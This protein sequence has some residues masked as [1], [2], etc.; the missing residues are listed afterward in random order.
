MTSVHTE[1]RSPPGLRHPSSHLQHQHHHFIHQSLSSTTTTTTSLASSSTSSSGHA[2]SVLQR[3]STFEGNKDVM[4][5]QPN[6]S[7]HSLAES[8]PLIAKPVKEGHVSLIASRFQQKSSVDNSSTITTAPSVPT[9]THSTSSVRPSSS[10]SDPAKKAE[11][12]SSISLNN[13][14]K[15]SEIIVK[16]PSRA[17]SEVSEDRSSSERISPL[18]S[19]PKKP[20][21]R[22]ES[23][24]AR[25][26]TARAMFEKMGSAEELDN[27]TLPP[28]KGSSSP[29]SRSSSVG[30]S[31]VMGGGGVVD[32]GFKQSSAYFRSRS[33]SPLSASTMSNNDRSPSRAKST[34][35]P[36]TEGV[37]SHMNGNLNSSLP[38]S[39]SYQNGLAETVGLVKSRRLSFQQK[40]NELGQTKTEQPDHHPVKRV[41]RPWMNTNQNQI[42]CSN[43]SNGDVSLNV[44][45]PS[46]NNSNNDSTDTA[47]ESVDSSRRISVKSGNAP[48]L[49]SSNVKEVPAKSA[50]PTLTTPV[51]EE[52]SPSANLDLPGD[53]R[54]LSATASNA[55]DSIED[56][57]RNWKKSPT[58]SPDDN[59]SMSDDKIE[60]DSKE[61][62]LSPVHSPK[63]KDSPSPLGSGSSNTH[64]STSGMSAK[65]ATPNTT[66]K[67]SSFRSKFEEI[68][69][70]TAARPPPVSPK[71]TPD[72]VK[73]FSFSKGADHHQGQN[74]PV[75][76]Q[77]YT[78]T[79][80]ITTTTRIAAVSTSSATMTNNSASN[81]NNHHPYS[82][83]FEFKSLD[84]LRSN[85]LMGD[86]SELSSL[87]SSDSSSS[88][89]QTRIYEVSANVIDEKEI[90]ELLEGPKRRTSDAS[91]TSNSSKSSSSSSSRSNG[92]RIEGSIPFVD[93]DLSEAL[94]KEEDELTLSGSQ[95]NPDTPAFKVNMAEAVNRIVVEKPTRLNLSSRYRPPA[96]L[97]ASENFSPDD[98]SDK[99]SSKAS[100]TVIRLNHDESRERID[101]GSSESDDFQDEI[102]FD[103]TI[104]SGQIGYNE[105]GFRNTPITM[106]GPNDRNSTA[107]PPDASI[108]GSVD[109]MTPTEAEKLL[110]TELSEKRLSDEQA[111]EVVALL[112]PPDKE[113]PPLPFESKEE[114]HGISSD[115]GS[116]IESYTLTASTKHEVDTHLPETGS[117]L[118]KLDSLV[119]RSKSQEPASSDYVSDESSVQQP[120]TKT[121]SNASGIATG[122][123]PEK[124]HEVHH[125]QKSGVHYFSDGH[126]WFEIAAIDESS[127]R[128]RL[129]DNF[130]KAPGKLRFSTEGIRQFSTFGVDEYDRRNED[131]DPVAASA[132]YELE[133]R[134]EKMDTF[135]VNLNKGKDGLGLSII[136]MGV[137]A[138]AGLEKLGIFIKTITPNGLAHR[139]GRI[140]VNDQIIEVDD[141]IDE[142]EIEELLEGPKRRTSDASSTSNSSKSSSSSSSRSNGTRIE[143]SIPFVDEDL[144]EALVK[145]EDELTLSGSQKNPDTP[146][147][148]VNMAEAVNRIVVEKPTRLNLSS[149]Y[150]PPASL[151]ASENFSPDDNSDKSS[152]KAST[153]VIRLNHD[154]SRERID[155]G[156]SESDDFQDE[157]QFDPT[158]SS[159]ASIDGSVDN[160]TPTEAEKLLSTELSEKRLSDEQA[161]EVVALLSLR[162]KSYHPFPSTKHEVDTHL[163]ETGSALDKLDSLVYRSKSQEPAS[164]DYVSDESSVQQPKTKTKS[165]ASGIA[166]GFVPEKIHEV[167]HDQKSPGKLRFSTEGIRQ[168]STFGVDEYDRRNEDVDP[169]AASAEYELEKRVEKM[170]T[171]PVNLNKGKD[172]LGLSIIGMGVGADA[173]LE[174]L[175]I[176]IKTITPNGLAHRDGR[177]Q[178]N[179]QIIEVD[180][181]ERADCQRELMAQ[182][183]REASLDSSEDQ[184][185]ITNSSTVEGEHTIQ[186]QEGQNDFL[187]DFDEAEERDEDDEEEEDDKT[188]ATTPDVESSN[189]VFGKESLNDAQ[190]LPNFSPED[191][192]LLKIKLEE[193]QT[194]NTEIEEEMDHIK[195]K[196]TDISKEEEELSSNQES[197]TSEKSDRTAK[198]ALER[199]FEELRRKYIQAKKVIAGL[200][201]HECFR[202]LQL[203]EQNRLL[204]DRVIQ[205]EQELV[206]TQKNAGMP[207]RLPYEDSL[208]TK[209]N[210][211]DFSSQSQSMSMGLH[212][213]EDISETELEDIS[214]S[215]SGPIK[216]E[217]DK[218]FPSHDLLDISASKSKAELV[219]K[220]ALSNRSKPSMDALRTSILRRSLSASSTIE[221]VTEMNH[222]SD[223]FHEGL[224]TSDSGYHATVTQVTAVRQHFGKAPMP[225]PSHPPEFMRPDYLGEFQNGQNQST[226]E[227]LP[228]SS[229]LQEKAPIASSTPTTAS[230]TWSKPRGAVALPGFGT[231]PGASGGVTMADQLKSRLEE[232]R[233]SGHSKDSPSAAVHGDSNAFVPESIITSMEH[234]VKVANDNVRKISPPISTN[235]SSSSSSSLGS[236][237]ATPPHIHAMNPHH[238][239]V[240]AQKH[241]PNSAYNE[242]GLPPSNPHLHQHISSQHQISHPI[243]IRFP[244][245]SQAQQQPQQTQQSLHQMRAPP[246]YPNYPHPG[247]GATVSSTS[248]SSSN[249]VQ[250]VYVSNSPQVV[251]HPASIEPSDAGVIPPEYRTSFHSSTGHGGIPV[252]V[253]VP[254]PHVPMLSGPPAPQSNSPRGSGTGSSNNSLRSNAA[255][256]D[257]NSH[258]R[259]DRPLNSQSSVMVQMVKEQLCQWLLAMEMR[260]YLTYFMDSEL[261]DEDILCLDNNGL[262]DLGVTNKSEREK[263]RKKIKELK[264]LYD[265]DKKEMEKER[266]RKDSLLKKAEKANR[267][268]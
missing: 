69:S 160:M 92:T 233:R 236:N 198:E 73:K 81:S 231:S 113:L 79:A 203:Q 66:G 20:V 25:F 26:N 140:Q 103:P 97:A 86:E 1:V 165:N 132:E 16:N 145:E 142:K 74:E 94:V 185:S 186:P 109:N 242:I 149:R 50:N 157:I 143:G 253:P 197:P 80:S 138:D 214:I 77:H 37:G 141:V 181:K 193:A 98:N 106:G 262:R 175:G 42:K 108:D 266:K 56:Y 78:A 267:K 222:G 220:S 125:D 182:L 122:F 152:S 10:S 227:N 196:L 115:I 201:R 161:K 7:S 18:R 254:P 224:P 27:S 30:R 45:T 96:S 40:Q 84:D 234:A 24:H 213:D 190:N 111:K 153:T 241:S 91:S 83:E 268:K 117:A 135:P 61:P 226:Y 229:P 71:P 49:L 5:P 174:K 52:P 22:T 38:S 53:R 167:H 93:E 129:P 95:K 191:I 100:T 184:T 13:S 17:P 139:D 134:V 29:T 151:A 130:Y 11:A 67:V 238:S 36:T 123:V 163:P 58:R 162:I 150:G 72:I 168:F 19:S 235:M 9:V 232:R 156:S 60:G 31:D 207:V 244:S 126:Y 76:D 133:K 228:I 261:S 251:P 46:N 255:G 264:A 199:E 166:T 170:D 218:L 70:T 239:V 158:I 204:T 209:A 210:N 114:E 116:S 189:M 248:S 205:L 195:S 159:D 90:E 68:Q 176:F 110:S 219:Q 131:V 15:T 75:Q 240:I 57:I 127:A 147:F 41:Q 237:Q 137:G 82:S 183:E 4:K 187:N 59:L 154:E 225:L 55:S 155:S 256:S 180:D 194:R 252:S 173:G 206:N 211:P 202:S 33:S 177:I 65:T 247:F 265:K 171:F 178:V 101:S 216:E 124:I 118:D 260:H 34:P 146:A 35:S 258:G 14:R 128:E 230:P 32:M 215:S 188:L 200:K 64:S 8:S 192:N 28:K 179:D 164:S 102:Q 105:G 259:N 107:F 172:G 246:P 23:H 243:P 63:S 121:K 250:T 51:I 99:S 120:K 223:D 144:S 43:S 47:S 6:R 88:A 87:V 85:K 62:S 2:P 48:S 169:V 89:N 44:S 112:S 249:A 263:V 12:G 54:P 245:P 39:S 136:G 257:P 212:L 3:R 104:S 208:L 21:S 148:K 217:L 119:Y 221:S